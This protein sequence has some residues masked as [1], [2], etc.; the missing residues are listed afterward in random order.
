[1]VQKSLKK[2]IIIPVEINYIDFDFVLAIVM[3]NCQHKFFILNSLFPLFKNGKKKKK[4]KKNTTRRSKRGSKE[5]PLSVAF[6]VCH[7]SQDVFTLS[8]ITL[9]LNSIGCVTRK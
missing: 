6:T 4:K 2:D 7:I 3:S 5:K 1:M 9:K 8:K